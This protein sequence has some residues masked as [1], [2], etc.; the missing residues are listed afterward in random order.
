M[1]KFPV[2]YLG[3]CAY[4][5]TGK[6]TLLTRLIP[7]LRKEGLRIGMVKHAHHQF[8]VDQPNKDSYRLREAGAC[9]TL[10]ASRKCKAWIEER[11]DQAN[12]PTLAEALAA[13]QPESLDLVLIEGFKKE[14]F[15]KIEL[16][17]PGLGTPLIFPNDKNVIAIATDDQLPVATG[18]LPLLDLNVPS[19]ISDFILHDFLKNHRQKISPY[20]DN[21]EFPTLI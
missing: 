18:A 11:A 6:T 16:H 19:Q 4:S 17:R 20:N 3:I 8:N 7:L 5:G 10:I 21:N 15:P 9:Q 13:L 1:I 14:Q 12:E 2:P